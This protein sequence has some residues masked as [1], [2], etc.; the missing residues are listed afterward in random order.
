MVQSLVALGRIRGDGFSLVV[1]HWD[2]TKFCV[3]TNPRFKVNASLFNLPFICWNVNVVASIIARFGVPL[4]ASHSTIQ[5]DDLTS[6]DLQFL[7][8]NLDAIHEL[9]E[10][11]VGGYTY[12]VR[13]VINF[14]TPFDSHDNHS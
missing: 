11:A 12:Q 1:N 3:H 5:R 7:C 8:D 10:V 2:E 6:S 9:I 14:S 4:R 13:L